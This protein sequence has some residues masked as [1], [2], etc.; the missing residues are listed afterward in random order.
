MVTFPVTAPAPG[1]RVDVGAVAGTAQRGMVTWPVAG[2][3][4]RV[5]GDLS[6]SALIAIAARTTVTGG[7]PAVR[8]PAGYA[9]VSIGPYR[10]PAVHEVRYGS[11]DLGEQAALGYGLTY[12][13]MS[14]GGGFEDQL[15]AVGARDGGLVARRPAVVSSVFGGNATL[16][17][18]PA[19]GTV[20]YI[21]YSGAQL[22]DRAVAA[23]QR[24]ATQALIINGRRW[25][26]L[27]QQTV[28]QV[29]EPG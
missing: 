23:L 20:A 2:S 14:N 28:D 29:N 7:R 21:G 18:E 16:A 19:P 13:G 1:R 27:D 8:A 22:D 17:W 9:L 26:E 4:A 12:T 6:E 11:A 5:R 24:L 25:Q 10:P 15:Y 3:Y